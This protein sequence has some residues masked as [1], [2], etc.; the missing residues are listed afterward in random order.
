MTGWEITKNNEKNKDLEF[1]N[2]EQ[3]LVEVEASDGLGGVGKSLGKEEMG[4]TDD[5]H[6]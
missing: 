3:K 6:C 4:V 1:R 2:E 5:V